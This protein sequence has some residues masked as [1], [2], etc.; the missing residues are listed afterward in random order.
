VHKSH[1]ALLLAVA[2]ACL[3]LIAGAALASAKTDLVPITVSPDPGAVGQVMRVAGC[4]FAFK[5]VILQT[6]APSGR[7][8]NYNVAMIS[9]G[10]MDTAGFIPTETGDYTVNILQASGKSGAEKVVASETVQ[11]D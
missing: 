10:C 3:V 4:G 9:T 8:Y 5:P 6:V 11:V 1:A 7:I 2:A